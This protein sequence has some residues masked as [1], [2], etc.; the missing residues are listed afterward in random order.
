MARKVDSAKA[1]FV[2]KIEFKGDTITVAGP[3]Q[4]G[5]STTLASLINKIINIPSNKAEI[6]FIL[7]LALFCISR[8]LFNCFP[9]YDLWTR[10]IVG[11]SVLDGF[12]LIKQDFFSYLPTHL[13]YDHEWGAS[14]IIYA[15]FK[16]FHQY[17]ILLL[18]CMN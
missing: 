1:E 7:V 2:S 5:K 6:I 15:F 12:S 10:F 8:C 13:W 14:V 11:S 3:T 16:V 17:G 4:S 9:D 18:K